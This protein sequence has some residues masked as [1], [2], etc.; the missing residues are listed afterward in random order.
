MMEDK[1]YFIGVDTYDLDN[2]NPTFAICV[3][4]KDEKEDIIVEYAGRYINKEEFDKDV[5]KYQEYYNCIP[6]K[7]YK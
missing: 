1:K 2:S 7:E 3:L 4:S 6:L 5:K